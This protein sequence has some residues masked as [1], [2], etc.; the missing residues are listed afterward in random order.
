VQ[1]AYRYVRNPMYLAVTATILGQVLLL[2]RPALLAYAAVVAGAMATF[3]YLYEEPTLAARYGH[4]YELYCAAVPRW[5]PRLRPWK[6]NHRQTV[7]PFERNP[8]CRRSSRPRPDPQPPP[9]QHAP[10]GC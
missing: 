6:P 5:R 4:H 3:V 2:G 10:A 1:G 9:R 7:R 8:T